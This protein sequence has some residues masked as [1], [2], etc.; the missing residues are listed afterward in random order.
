MERSTGF[1]KTFAKVQNLRGMVFLAG[2]FLLSLSACKTGAPVQKTA[3]LE[4]YLRDSIPYSLASHEK[5]SEQ[6]LIFLPPAI[7]TVQ[8]EETELYQE[9]FK[10]GYDILC[11]YQPPAEG[12]FFYSRKSLEFKGQQVQNAQN[13]ISHLRKQKKIAGSEHS[14]LMGIE[15]GAYMIP[16]LMANNHIDT[17]IYITAS[18]FSMY[19]SLQRIAEGRMEWNAAR[20]KFVKDKFGIDSLRVFKQKVE[21]VENLSSELYSLGSF[22]NM[23]WL[24][25]HANYMMEEYRLTP[26][27]QYWIFYEDYPLYK[28]SDLDYLKLLDKTKT[29]ASGAYQVLNGYQ[30]FSKENWEQLEDVILPYFKEQS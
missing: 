23:Y 27:H 22:T 15:Q 20:Q 5:V 18:P 3:Y 10:A 4:P 1:G 29:N 8:F 6:L 14:I 21:D 28:A 25:Y 11:I 19:M 12:A 24:S 2:I 9:I 17:A 26:G 7:D 30:S 16:S 13:L